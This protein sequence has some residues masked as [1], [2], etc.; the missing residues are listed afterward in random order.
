MRIAQMNI[1]CFFIAK[2]KR[3]ERETTTAKKKVH[4]APSQILLLF[5]DV[6]NVNF[7][8]NGKF[9]GKVLYDD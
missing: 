4:K 2:D 7:R 5:L 9:Q 1:W 6:E 3:E 8:D